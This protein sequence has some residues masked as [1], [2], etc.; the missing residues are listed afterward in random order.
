MLVIDPSGRVARVMAA[1]RAEDVAYLVGGPFGTPAFDAAGRLAYRGMARPVAAR[2]ATSADPMPFQFPEQPDSAPIVRFD[3]ATRKSDT[4]G[5]FK[6]A[7]SVTNAARAEGG[8]IT[9][10]LTVNPMQ[11]L[12]DWALLSDGTLAIV[13]GRDFHIDWIGADRVVTATPPMSFAWRR[14]SPEDRLAVLDSAKTAL[15]REMTAM[16]ARLGTSSGAMTGSGGNVARTGAGHFRTVRFF[17]TYRVSSAMGGRE[18]YRRHSGSGCRW[19]PFRSHTI[20][21]RWRSGWRCPARA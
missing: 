20:G 21:S 7:R 4:L 6:T 8:A 13:R 12:D 15:D 14:M 9:V 2:H 5:L 17:R 16:K 10:T 3:F 11:T 19:W 1:P 18:S